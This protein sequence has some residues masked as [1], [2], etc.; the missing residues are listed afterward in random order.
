MFYCLKL[1]LLNRWTNHR[2]KLKEL[3]HCQK[4]QYVI[5]ALVV[6]DC[7][8]VIAELIVDVEVLKGT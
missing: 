7:A 6:L 5:V 4:A 8:I 1:T 2:T 3:L